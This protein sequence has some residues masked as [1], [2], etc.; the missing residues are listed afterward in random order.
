MF[1]QLY[2][3]KLL[4]TLFFHSDFSRVLKLA[5]RTKVR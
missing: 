3:G 5:N 2:E 1:L 4:L